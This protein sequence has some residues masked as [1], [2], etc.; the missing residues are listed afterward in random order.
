MLSQIL[1]KAIL[2]MALVLAVP[3]GCLGFLTDGFGLSVGLL[4]GAGLA[5]G[6][7]VGLVWLAQRLLTP[8][9]T[10][11]VAAVLLGLKL[12]VVLAGAWLALTLVD[13]LGFTIGLGVGLLAVVLGAQNGQASEEGQ[14]AIAAQE[15]RLRAQTSA[16]M[17][18]T[19]V[20]SR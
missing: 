10:V 12:G 13:P 15:A 14:R 16:E 4:V 7:G 19:H 6:S 9:G 1:T 20:E 8:D 3:A 17:G 18:D 2:R 5:V 11:T